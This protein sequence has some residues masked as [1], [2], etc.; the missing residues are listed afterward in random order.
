MAVCNNGL[1]NKQIVVVRWEST[2]INS[3]VVVVVF[4]VVTEKQSPFEV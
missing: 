2:F 4:V 3:L 1:L